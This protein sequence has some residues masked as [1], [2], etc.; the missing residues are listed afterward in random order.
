M[1]LK[2]GDILANKDTK[3]SEIKRLQ[4]QIYEYEKK[5]N[6]YDE[7]FNTFVEG[8]VLELTS[9]IKTIEIKTLQK[10]F[11]NPD[12][13]IENIS[14][15]LSYYYIINGDIFQLYDLIF[16][17]PK[18]NY[19]IT[20]F[21][22]DGSYAKDMVKIR[23]FLERKI[24]YKKLT[25]ELLIQ[26]THEGTLIGTWLGGKN[27]P[28]FYTFS[29]LKYIFPYGMNKGKMRAV[30]DLK[31]LDEMKV[32]ERQALYENLKPLI[33]EKKYE[34]YK[35]TTDNDKKKELRY[36][37]LPGDKTLVARTH[38]LY[39]NQRYGMPHGTQ[40]MF[41]ILHK[42]KMKELEQSIADKVIRAMA[43]L[44]F[45]GKDENDQRVQETDKSK[46]F[47]AVKRALEKS[48]KTSGGTV[49]VIAIP[50]FAELEFA[51]FKGIDD[52]LAPEKY[53]SANNDISSALGQ[54]KV[55]TNGTTGNFASAKLNLE[56]IYSKIGVLL[57]EIEEVFN[58][59]ITIVLG[60]KKGLNYKFEFDK[61]IPLSKKEKVDSL[62]KLQAQGYSVKK[63]TDELG[64]DFD[65][66]ISQSKYEIE[67][68]KLREVIIPAQSTFTLTGK[69]ESG[70]PTTD[71]A[72]NENTIQS[73]E[74]DGN[75]T[76]KANV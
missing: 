7:V 66:Y 50:D 28:Y 71:D 27:D 1:V 8:W 11:S 10:W 65:E 55:L 13:N 54:S 64:I 12:D 2:G 22:R 72:E 35:N 75:N 18:L 4:D 69:G 19:K 49:S 5:Y 60:E 6:T 29:N 33:T 52:A 43:V 48:S 59:L 73:K 26:L 32:T 16:S 34:K 41:D 36:E 25:R 14:N 24:N 45:K 46:V 23:Q 56:V 20:A 57:E 61:E 76:P 15:L 51:D 58:Q 63:I 74:I 3:D 53:N 21:D 44:K 30:F 9:S 67:V 31:Y 40:A 68:L 47:N 39:Q 37:V 62:F 17:L 38:V 70:S 42:Q